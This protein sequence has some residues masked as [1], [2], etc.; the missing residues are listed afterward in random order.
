MVDRVSLDVLIERI[1]EKYETG[2]TWEQIRARLKTGPASRVRVPGG[3]G[4]TVYLH[5]E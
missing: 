3:G 5:R 4:G 1:V 2:R